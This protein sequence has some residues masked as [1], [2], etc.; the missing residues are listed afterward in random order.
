[1]VEAEQKTSLLEKKNKM[2]GPGGWVLHQY[3]CGNCQELGAV[4]ERGQWGRN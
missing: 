1:M 2:E 3:L 4:L